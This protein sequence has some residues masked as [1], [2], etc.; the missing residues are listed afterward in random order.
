MKIDREK[1]LQAVKY[2]R[3]SIELEGLALS[4]LD[5][6]TAADYIDGRVTLDEFTGS[7]PCP[8]QSSPSAT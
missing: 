1:R 8:G 5:E 3:A 6:Q 2:A 7:A 4:V